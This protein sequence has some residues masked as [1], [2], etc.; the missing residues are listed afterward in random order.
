MKIALAYLPQ[1]PWSRR[2]LH[3]PLTRIA[4]PQMVCDREDARDSVRSQV[5]HI[6]VSF[7]ID[8][9]FERHVPVVHYQMNG[10]V[11]PHGIATQPAETKHCSIEPPAQSGIH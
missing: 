7:V 10:G 3:L 1:T 6:R 11:G 4:D 5:C 9:P 8:H 2:D